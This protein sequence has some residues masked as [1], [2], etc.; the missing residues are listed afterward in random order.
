MDLAIVADGSREIPADQYAGV[1]QLLGS[2]VGQL[3]VSQQPGQAGPQARV[4]V[5]QQSSQAKVEFGLQTYGN[6]QQM[7]SQ[8]DKMRQLGGASALGQTLEVALTEV[9]L[10]A[11]HPRRRRALMVVVG[12]ETEPADRAKLQYVS[13]KAQCEGVALFVVAVG[14]G[15]S[16]RQVEQLASLPLQQ[17]L[18]H[19]EQLK[20]D[21]Q[22]YAQRFFRLFLSA[23]NSESVCSGS[24]S[25]AA[26]AVWL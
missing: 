3:A 13:Q 23:L 22:G 8:I 19:V 18:V 6:H 5:V 2:V 11:R 15:Y 4:A 20:A 26:A 9:L 1:Q 24:C 14:D 10:K 7:R 21:E 17:H 16:R 12:S 25:G